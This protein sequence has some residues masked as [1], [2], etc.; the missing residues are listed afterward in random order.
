LNDAFASNNLG[1][2]AAVVNGQQLQIT[3]NGYGAGTTFQVTSDTTGAGTTGLAGATPGAPTSFAGVDVAGTIN[4][5]AATG[6]G[7]VLAAPLGDRALNGL[8]VSVT[9]TGISTLTDLG[10]FSYSPGVAQQLTSLANTMTVSGSGT[11]T[12]EVTGLEAEATG[13]NRQITLENQMAA[14][15]RTLLQNEF[16]QMEATLGSLKN[17][18]SSLAS[19]IA[20]IVTNQP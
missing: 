4:G 13:L 11:L 12:S 5:V 15:Q 2:T 10:V 6:T 16:A 3:S 8:A 19:S 18:S 14:S 1:L 17:Q 9:T 7:Q 20:G